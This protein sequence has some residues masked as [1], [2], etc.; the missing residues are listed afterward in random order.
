MSNR[1]WRI[2]FPVV[3]EP[4][5]QI[6]I[7]FSDCCRLALVEMQLDHWLEI[8]LEIEFDASELEVHEDLLEALRCVPAS[9]NLNTLVCEAT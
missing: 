9:K 1:R 4:A 3:A 8:A 2:S 7:A 5:R 6:G